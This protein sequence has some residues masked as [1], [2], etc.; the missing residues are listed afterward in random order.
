MLLAVLPMIVCGQCHAEIVTRYSATPMANT[1]GLVEPAKEPSGG[2][3]HPTSRT[4]FDI[5]KS[6][7]HLYLQWG[8]R[9]QALEFFIGSRR[10]GRSYGFS[11]DGYFYQAPVGYYA[12][13]HLWDMAPGYENDRAPDFNRPITA[14][15][16]FCHA[17]GAKAV[18]KTL[19]RFADLSILSGISCERC[20]GDASVHLAHPEP[21]NIVNP[22]R[23]AFA[24]RDSICEQ[25]HLSGEARIPQPGRRLEDFRPGQRLSTYL[26][27][28]VRGSRPTGIRVTSHAEALAASACRQQSGQQL[29]CGSCHDP[30]GR[31]VNYRE[32]CLSCHSLQACP[33]SRGESRG[34]SADCIGCHMVKGRAYDGGHTVFT[35]HSIPRRPASSQSGKLAPVSLASYFPEDPASQEASRNLGIAWMQV[36]ENF[37]EPRLFDKAW[38]LLRAAASRG[39]Q[40]PLLYAKVAEAL[41]F[42]SQTAEAEKAYRL[43]LEQDPGQLDVLVRLAALLER[44]GRRTEATALRK[45]AAAILPR[46]SE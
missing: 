37:G 3:F 38:P 18:P 44:S 1:S 45:R 27:I 40:D 15:C 11:E 29:W 12:N 36:A 26:A 5:V 31:Q 28:F 14:D 8:S 32:K 33:V 24:E 6:G 19:N 46:Q 20:H 7:G 4:R 25:C 13:R 42:A 23:L 43:S 21:G 35:D 39:L 17:T 41:E 34:A 16:L 2:F 10:M 30:H 9:R 22:R